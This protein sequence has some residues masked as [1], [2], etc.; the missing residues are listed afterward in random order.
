MNAM[1]LLPALGT[2]AL[3]AALAACSTSPVGPDYRK[4]DAALARRADATAPFIGT[5]DT[6]P[7]APTAR[8][9]TQA[10]L[11]SHWWRLF[12]DPVL[13]DLVARALDHNTDL[14]QAAA[15]LARV[16]ALQAEVDGAAHPTI[17]VSGGPSF[18]HASGL[19]VLKPG[20]EP[21]SA[22][23]GSAGVSVAYQ[24]DLLGQIR[25]A[26]EAA[27]AGTDAASAALDVAR[28]SVAAGTARAYADVCATGQRL[29]AAQR[30]ID[31]QQ[32]AVDVTRKLQQAGRVGEVDAA[33]ARSQLEQLRA[34]IPPLQA[35]R[36][37][38]AFRLATL[39]GEPPQSLPAGIASCSSPP[40]VAGA[41]PV[42]DGA[43]LLQRRPDVRQAERE[44]AAATARIGVAIAD[45]YPKVTLGLSAGTAGPL[46]R[47][48]SRDTVSWSLGPLISWTLPNT[49]VAD[50]RVA[51][52]EASAQGAFAK[53]DGTVLTALRETETALS[54]YAHELDRQAALQVSVDEAR[55][56]AAQTR[57]LYEGGKVGYLETL[58]A[59]RSLAAG[60]ASLAAS[61][62][63][64]VDD[65]VQ[66]FLTLGG[67]WER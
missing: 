23:H 66:V 21:P 59:E 4:P 2:V 28:V 26:S 24:V 48:G 6:S 27:Q 63:Q 25:R 38:A 54:T 14:R 7:D 20:Y 62:A 60:E 61:H 1:K 35:Q 12:D 34:A 10:P 29:Q 15:N 31:L 13:D 43:A 33:R 17:G 9:Y 37:G 19:S 3:A 8:P 67:G 16:Q 30:S 42:G 47:L 22:W 32:Q 40:Q 51:Q 46:D 39:I 11:P 41:M 50:A 55:T 45:R 49:G 36:Q 52:A 5:R 53:F 18:G 56:V 44:L 64:L 58:D 65:Q 57:K